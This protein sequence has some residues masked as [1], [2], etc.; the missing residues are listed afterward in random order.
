[1]T[2]A[3][4]QGNG[5]EGLTDGEPARVPAYSGHPPMCFSLS[6]LRFHSIYG[7]KSRNA[8]RQNR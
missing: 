5:A 4:R 2:R 6:D 8:R 7:K 1:M 3:D